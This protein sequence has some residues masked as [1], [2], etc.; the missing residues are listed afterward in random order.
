VSGELGAQNAVAGGGRY[1]GLSET[2]GGP[3]VPALG[4]ALGLDRLVMILPDRQSEP[5]QWKPE[6]F[7]AYMGEAAFQKALE[8]ARTLRHQGHAC[9]L[10]FSEGRL[11]N[12]M[13]LADKIGAEHVLI[14]GE[15]ELARERYSIKRLSDSRQWEVTLPELVDYLNSRPQAAGRL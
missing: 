11:K 4:F 8:I 9:Y 7:L 3:R 15:E 5:R 14:V 6:L 13:R 10:D 1:D 2:L 12:Q